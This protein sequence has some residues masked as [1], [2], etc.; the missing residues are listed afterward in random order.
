MQT[1]ADTAQTPS[2]R[3]IVREARSE[4]ADRCARIFYDAF[5]SIAGRPNLLRVRGTIRWHDHASVGIGPDS[6]VDALPPF[7]G[8]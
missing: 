3:V 4:D 8:G 2:S 7:A 5:E 1:L 6:V